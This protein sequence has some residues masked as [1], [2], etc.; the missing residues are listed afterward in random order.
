M[1]DQQ[2][3]FERWRW[4]ITVGVVLSLWNAVHH[5]ARHEV[6]GHFWPDALTR[7]NLWGLVLAN[8]MLA[9]A[10]WYAAFQRRRAA[11]S[12]PPTA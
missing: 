4:A 7:L 3:L 11:N 6:S 9:I 12:E 5:T 2:S 8:T 10:G 1:S